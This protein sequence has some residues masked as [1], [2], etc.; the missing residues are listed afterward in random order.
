MTAD[1]S[2]AEKPQT[3]DQSW[4]ANVVSLVM[5]ILLA[6]VS[7]WPLASQL[8]SRLVVGTEIA[9]TVPLFNAWTLWWNVDRLNRGLENYWDAPIFFPATNTL[10]LSEPQPLLILM[11]PVMWFGGS[12]FLAANL[13]L[14]ISLL[15]NG[16]LGRWML[17]VAGMRPAV[18]TGGGAAMLLLPIAHWQIGVQQLVPIWGLL[19][20]WTALYQVTLTIDSK[21]KVSWKLLVGRGVSLGLAFSISMMLCAHHGL[22]LAL[23]LVIAIPLLAAAM[24]SAPRLFAEESAERKATLQIYRGGSMLGVSAVVVGLLCGSLVYHLRAMP[25]DNVSRPESTIRQLSLPLGDYLAV[26]GR[27]Y[28]KWGSDWARDGWYLSPGWAKLGLAAIGLVGGLWIAPR[29]RWTMVIGSVGTTALVLSLGARLNIFGWEPWWLIAEYVP[30]FAQVRNV[31]RFAYF[32]QIGSVLLAAQAIDLGLDRLTANRHAF[33]RLRYRG[34]GTVGLAVCGLWATLDPWPPRIGLGVV[35]QATAQFADQHSW[36]D[37]LAEEHKIYRQQHPAQRVG[38]LCLPMAA[39]DHV[40]E[41]EI[42]TDWMLLSSEHGVPLVNGYSGFFPEVY[43]QLRD[44][45]WKT[46]VT[47]GVANRLWHEGARWIVVDLRRFPVDWGESR[48]IGHVVFTRVQGT[49]EEPAPDEPAGDDAAIVVYRMTN[50]T[51][52]SSSAAGGSAE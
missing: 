1:S 5:Y 19:W 18:A 43:F 28:A 26:Y 45:V 10:A 13:Y 50:P 41:F 25:A 21:Q 7:T 23:L 52:T 49:N 30:G 27:S 11:A 9:R 3:S 6:I 20:T 38:A 31:F 48:Q 42:T 40:G 15:L 32:V 36:I 4:R 14:L 46:G 44:T 51:A 34:L 35:T 8:G 17:L 47:A 24:L 12:V 29:R 22:F 39:G 2:A 37:Q 16:M 33:P